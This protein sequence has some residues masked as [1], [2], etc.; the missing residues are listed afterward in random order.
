MSGTTTPGNGIAPTATRTGSSTS[1]ATCA[2]DL[3]ASTTCPYARTLAS[4][5][6]LP[7]GGRTIIP[8]FPTSGCKHHETLRAPVLVLLPESPD[9]ALRK[10][11]GVRVRL[12]GAQ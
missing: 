5:T 2:V 1:R 7:G 8:D 10:R 6:G 9:R 11:H 3:P 12:P 4:I